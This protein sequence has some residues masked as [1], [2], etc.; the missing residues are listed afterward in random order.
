[1]RHAEVELAADDGQII[2]QTLA[3]A[4]GHS[5]VLALCD[6]I[7][8]DHA[9]PRDDL[10]SFGI[11]VLLFQS[12]ARFPVDPIEI[13]FFARGGCRMGGKR[14]PKAEGSPSISHAAPFDNACRIS[15]SVAFLPQ[16]IA[17]AGSC[18]HHLPAHSLIM[19]I[20]TQLSA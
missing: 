1:M 20:S 16:K 4:C 17:P 7:A 3:N 5:G 12:I 6:L 13:D 2:L 18:M 14:P 8:A 15:I 9:I 10:A 11:D 19:S